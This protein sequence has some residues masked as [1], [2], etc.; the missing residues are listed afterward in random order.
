MYR[1]GGRGL[2]IY[3]FIFFIF[4]F[5]FVFYIYRKYHKLKYFHAEKLISKIY[6]VIKIA[7]TNLSKVLV[8]LLY[9]KIGKKNY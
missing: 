3:S 5:L 7:N 8:F 4:Y 6:T 1:E 9:F 2:S